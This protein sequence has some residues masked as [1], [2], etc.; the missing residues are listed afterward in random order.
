MLTELNIPIA[1]KNDINEVSILDRYT[2]PLNI[3]GTVMIYNI[4]DRNGATEPSS[5]FHACCGLSTGTNFNES[6]AWNPNLEKTEELKQALEMFTNKVFNTSAHPNL[7]ITD[8]DRLYYLYGEYYGDYLDENQVLQKG[9]YHTGVDVVAEPASAGVD[10]YS[11]YGGEVVLVEEP[12]NR[13]TKHGA[14]GIYNE[15]LDVTFFYLHMITDST[16]YNKFMA[17]KS[18]KSV[19][20]IGANVR[21][22]TQSDVGKYAAGKTHLHFEVQPG[23]TTTYAGIE[24]LTSKPLSSIL[25]YGYMTGIL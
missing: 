23:R 21:I 22:G 13:T 10:V 19:C 20:K 18:E 7:N 2:A 6:T 5:E 9:W 4:P 16:L 3:T 11:L 14:V 25:P 17:C 12:N 15:I 8:G 24:K 1:P